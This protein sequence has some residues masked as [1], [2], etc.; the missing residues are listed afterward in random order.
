M[1]LARSKHVQTARSFLL[2]GKSGRD[3]VTKSGA[4]NKIPFR[5]TPGKPIDTRSK[6]G[7]GATSVA[8]M[9]TSSRVDRDIWSGSERGR[10]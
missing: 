7:N 3:R 4:V 6:T 10:S 8:S 1:A 9:S 2:T 5:T